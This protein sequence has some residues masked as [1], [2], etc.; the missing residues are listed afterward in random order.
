[1]QTTETQ[2]RLRSRGCYILL[3]LIAVVPLLCCG[4]FAYFVWYTSTIPTAP[5]P[6]GSHLL[7]L[8]AGPGGHWSATARYWY[9][10]KYSVA[11]PPEEVK[12]YYRS[13]GSN[14]NPFGYYSVQILPPIPGIDEV[15]PNMNLASA[16]RRDSTDPIGET[17][18]LIEVSWDPEPPPWN[19]TY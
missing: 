9:Y 2:P 17:I 14:A 11:M 19:W 18:I 3:A 7:S 12:A 15:P 6:P 13:M 16:V 4:W 5:V 1:M 10:E 8:D